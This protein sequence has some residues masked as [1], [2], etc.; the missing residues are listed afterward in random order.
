LQFTHD[1]VGGVFLDA[2]LV[3]VLAVL[4][5]AFDIERRAFFDV[6]RRFQRVGRKT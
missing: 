6:S 4:E 3:G 1:D 5:A 2:G